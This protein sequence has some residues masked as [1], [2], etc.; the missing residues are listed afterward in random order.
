MQNVIAECF[1][2]IGFSVEASETMTSVIIIIAVYAL[3]FL[4]NI[5]TK[6]VLLRL[7][8]RI[9]EQSRYKWC[10]KLYEH[11]MFHRTAHLVTPLI[12]SFFAG[13]FPGY[14]EW[15]KRVLS[16]YVTFILLLI[17][18]SV[19]NAADDIYRTYDISKTRPIKGFLQVI[20][21]V[22]IVIGIIIIVSS[23]I[24]Q[25]PLILIG[26]LGA[27]SAV[28]MLVFQSSILGFVAGIQLTS[29]DMVRI[30][31]W[32][33]M[34]KYDAD[35][36]VTELTLTT[37]KVRN[38]DNS[39]TTIPAQAMVT[40]SFRNWR[41]MTESGARR[42]KRSISIDISSIKFCTEEML[43]YFSRIEYLK[44]Y[45]SDK[46]KEIEEYNR[47][48]NIDTSVPVNGRRMTN[49]GTFRFYV[50]N[51][52]ANHPGIRKDKTVLVHQLPP[53]TEGLPLEICAFA[54]TTDGQKYEKIQADIFDHLFAVLPQFGLRAYQKPSG[55]DLSIINRNGANW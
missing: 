55:F 3:C 40:D 29:N 51:Y 18:D 22:S 46:M 35:G 54:D 44:D 37:V 9:I 14:E 49:I 17:I 8:S 53:T 52:V 23:L 26:G 28:I 2:N 25:N 19:L 43:D 13:C 4:A 34:P 27:M 36:T 16:A 15:I 47:R 21:I 24:G 31:D 32:I 11:R 30:G 41:G 45:I 38:F 20:K 6:K 48:L 5:I 42:I 33:Q 10:E 12:V 1:S 39:I 50:Q 7:V